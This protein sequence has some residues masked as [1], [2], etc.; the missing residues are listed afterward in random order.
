[1][2]NQ[3]IGNLFLDVINSTSKHK[4]VIIFKGIAYDRKNIFSRIYTWTIFSIQL[5]FHLI[6]NSSKYEKVIAVSNPPFVPMIVYLT[7]CKYSLILYD[8]YPQILKQLKTNNIV[9]KIV[10]NIWN[11][12]NK[13]IYNSADVIITLS[14]NMSNEL[15]GYFY[16]I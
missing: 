12:C 9:L 3:T 4:N 5:F 15:R 6:V 1:M 10:I 14:N 7:R 8:L 16:L 2:V 11:R 13:K